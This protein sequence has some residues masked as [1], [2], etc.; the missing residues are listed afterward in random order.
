MPGI[1][2]PSMGKAVADPEGE[3]D[4]DGKKRSQQ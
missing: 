3:V 4:A 1:G 2:S